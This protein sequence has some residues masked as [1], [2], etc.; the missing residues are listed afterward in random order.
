MN[1][2]LLFLSQYFWPEETATAEMLSGVA[3]ELAARGFRVEAIAGQPA[4]HRAERLLRRLE[5]RGVVVRRIRSTRFDKNRSLG[6]VLNTA[7][8]AGS[9]LASTVMRRR[10][11]VLLAATTPPLL[12]WVARL[13]HRLRGT[14]YVLL[15]QDVYPQI[16][17]ALG[18]LRAGSAVARFWR[19]LNRRAYRGAAAIVALGECMAEVLRSELPPDRQSKVVAIP[20][21]A[22]GDAIRPRPREQHP[23]LA[24]WQLATRFVVQYSGNIGLFHDIETVLAA[25]DWLRGSNV[26]FLFLGD[27]GQLPGLRRAVEER[28]LPNV[29]L[30][31]FQPRERLPLTLTACD[32]GL[33]TLKEE[34]TGFCVPSKLYGI[35]AAGK[36]VLAVMN[37]RC[38]VAR[39]VLRYDCGAVVPPGDGETLAAEILHLKS[40]QALRLQMGWAARRAYEEH[41]TLHAVADQYVEMI[42]RLVG[43]EPAAEPSVEMADSGSVG[44]GPERSFDASTIQE[45]L[46]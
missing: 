18:R 26:H 30:L 34:A 37:R 25:A 43:E 46:K 20:N 15:I 17:V 33:V 36:P 7:T 11:S 32:V 39:V 29:T 23:L 8:F 41:Y 5:E 38:E 3:F 13:N 42:G 16:A 4:Y 27:G 24:E 19:R 2:S 10:P 22:N 35:L 21:W 1:H 28:R 45:R 12:P 40:D 9:A 44:T 14:P 31:P 6:R